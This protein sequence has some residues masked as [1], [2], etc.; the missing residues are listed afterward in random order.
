MSYSKTKGQTAQFSDVTE[1]SEE[2]KKQLSNH[3]LLTF[4]AHQ[5]AIRKLTGASKNKSVTPEDSPAYTCSGELSVAFAILYNQLTL[6]SLSFGDFPGNYT[7]S[8]EG[9]GIGIGGG[10]AWYTGWFS[11]TPTQLVNAGDIDYTVGTAAI[12]TTA[13][14]YLN[15]TLVGVIVAAGLT[16]GAGTFAGSGTF[17]G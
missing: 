15:D 5:N 13:S 12:G 17:A 4:K 6:E 7:Y 8:G 16:I 11:L 1:P 10:V 14:F 9:W 3:A 2:I